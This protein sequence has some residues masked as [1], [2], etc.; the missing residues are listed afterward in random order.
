M[1]VL[2]VQFLLKISMILSEGGDVTVRQ[3]L[4]LVETSSNKVEKK[5]FHLSFKEQIHP[6][7]ALE[8]A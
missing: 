3:Y 5:E 7:M 1:L 4:N 6:Y 2:H 8:S